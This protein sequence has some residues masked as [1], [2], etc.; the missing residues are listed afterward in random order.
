MLFMINLAGLLI[1]AMLAY[2]GYRRGILRMASS[3]VALALA[4][5][6]AQPFSG[7]GSL[8]LG[9][10]VPRVFL[11]LGGALVAGIALFVLLDLV[12]SI[13]LNRQAK[14]REEEGLPKVLP[15]EAYT[16]LGLGALWGLLLLTLIGVGV[17]AIGRTQ[18][19]IR[20]S[21]AEVAY[22]VKH[23]GPW[24]ALAPT[25]L[26][27]AEASGAESMASAVE[28][29]V[30]SPLIDRFNPIDEKVEKTLGDLSI[31]CNDPALY[32]LFQRHPKIQT[33]M[34]NPVLVGLSQDPEIASAI[35]EGNYKKLMDNSKICEVAQDKEMIR[36]LK[37]LQIDQ[38]LQE[39]RQQSQTLPEARTVG[40]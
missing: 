8:A 24:V 21:D 40:R 15:W 19:A 16:G 9:S 22:R 37:D 10:S 27:M 7:L 17:S 1:I 2:S 25:Q 6:L 20:R 29:S 34:G 26:T 18:R 33:M 39:I 36:Q 3:L 31:V 11:P 12:L 35:Q 30:F 4:G 32:V 28:E 38:I 14:K 13:P 23:P 5:L